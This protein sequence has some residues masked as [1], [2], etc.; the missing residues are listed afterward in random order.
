MELAQQQ[1]PVIEIPQPLNWS[2]TYLDH[3]NGSSF[4]NSRLQELDRSELSKSLRKIVL[5]T[6]QDAK[7]Y[8]VLFGSL[9]DLFC[10]MKHQG[11]ANF[12]KSFLMNAM[13]RSC[14]IFSEQYLTAQ[15][16]ARG[17]GDAL[18][19]H[20]QL[21]LGKKLAQIEGKK[22]EGKKLLKILNG[23]VIFHRYPSP[24]LDK[25]PTLYPFTRPEQCDLV[26]D[27]QEAARQTLSLLNHP[28]D[29][30]ENFLVFAK[31]EGEKEGSIKQKVPKKYV[32]LLKSLG[33]CGEK[34]STALSQGNNEILANLHH[35]INGL[36]QALLCM[37]HH[38]G[39]EYLP[40]QGDAILTH[41]QHMDELIEAAIHVKRNEKRIH[42]HDLQTYRELRGH[43][44]NEEEFEMINA[45]N[46]KWGDHYPN[47]FMHH[48]QSTQKAC[49]SAVIWRL[50]SL[51]IALNRQ[52]YA[53][54]F[55]P[56]VRKT[57]QFHNPTELRN[58]LLKI[59]RQ[60]L[61]NA[62]QILTAT[63]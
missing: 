58:F 37:F 39:I 31:K 36:E 28:D 14:S 13:T 51:Q 30:P 34:V 33:R 62:E 49:P 23:G 53:N 4:L 38:E 2:P 42:I 48:C 10:A 41:L 59:V 22:F 9:I 12:F 16:L 24:I 11:N 55:A 27:L 15:L 63:I 56:N 57:A 46:C 21:N 40:L 17:Q 3:F 20:S 61:N 7:H 25:N 52:M 19:N 54:G 50:D 1:S 6:Y 18:L 26:K 47:R 29:F 43:E 8:F 45:L 32:P 35:H 60:M 44:A 5:T